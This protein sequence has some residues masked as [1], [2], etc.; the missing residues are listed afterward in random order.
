MTVD[1]CHVDRHDR[2]VITFSGVKRFSDVYDWLFA[3]YNGYKFGIVLDCSLSEYPEPDS[4]IY[5]HFLD[6]L[7][8]E[9]AMEAGYVRYDKDT[10]KH[11]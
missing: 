7:M 8:D 10:Y 11:R 9:V 6:E 4:K 3:H 2:T 5:V 1:D